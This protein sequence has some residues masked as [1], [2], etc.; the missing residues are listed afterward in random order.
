MNFGFGIKNL[1]DVQDITNYA[2]NEVHSS[3][4]SYQFVAYGRRFL[5][6]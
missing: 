2:T 3:S 4:N 5:L 1:L 6:Q